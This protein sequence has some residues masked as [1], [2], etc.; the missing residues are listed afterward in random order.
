MKPD[1]IKLE[2]AATIHCTGTQEGSTAR[3]GAHAVAYFPLEMA[4]AFQSPD[5]V[6]L[7]GVPVPHVKGPISVIDL[8]PVK[9][10]ALEY[11]RSKTPGNRWAIDDETGTALCVH[12]KARF[13]GAQYEPLVWAQPAFTDAIHDE[14]DGDE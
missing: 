7:A 12:C 8:E 14:E 4:L 2:Y 1:A 6:T 13:D 10:A 5:P 3:C 11:F 9:A